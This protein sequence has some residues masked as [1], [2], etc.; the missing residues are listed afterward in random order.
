MNGMDV[1]VFGGGP[2]GL[3][4][5]LALQQGGCR[6]AL[7]DAQRPPIDKACGEGLMP[8]AVWLLRRL[9]VALDERDGARLTGI[10]FH[11]AHTSAFAAFGN[12]KGLAVRRTRLQGRM[13]ARAAKMG[14]ALHWGANVQALAGGG[15][16]SAGAPIH[17]DFFVI[18][19]GL[20][21]TL[22]A[23]SG[24]RERNCYSTRYA[25]RQQFQCAP[26]SNRVEVHWRH[27]EQLYITPLNNHEIGVTLI[28]GTQGRRLHEALPDFP[29]V[30]NRLGGAAPA[31]GMR[32][33]VT[34]TRSLRKVVRG[35]LAVL[36]D[37]SGSVDAVTGDGLMSAF[38]QAHALAD[39]IAA[40][41]LKRYAVAH[42]EM[43]K[44]PRRMAR[45]LLLLDRYPWLER[46]FTATMAT[47]PK[48]FAAMLR[49]HLAE[50]SWPAFAWR[51]SAAIW[52]GRRD[53]DNGPWLPYA[54]KAHRERGL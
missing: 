34:R 10:Y 45:L 35:N 14:I 43:A 4:A 37:A 2:A 50:Q 36:G 52:N 19:D 3:A 12:G 16:T 18:A 32:G 41:D 8:E 22:A 40:G 29:A 27:G 5:A 9:G 11:D 30:A 33:A 46:S 25:S 28:T 7:Y 20:C 49:V 1:A 13:A 21:S 24:F 54:E 44:A 26:W 23:A 15:F 47:R 42:A 48:S 38:R 17:A 6:V 51:E 53:T 31:S 39:A